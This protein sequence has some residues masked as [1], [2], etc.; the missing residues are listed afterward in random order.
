MTSLDLKLEATSVS[1]PVVQIV[2]SKYLTTHDDKK[3]V[4]MFVHKTKRISILGISGLILLFISGS[5][6]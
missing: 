4:K 1:L 5:T 6:F 2:W 3:R